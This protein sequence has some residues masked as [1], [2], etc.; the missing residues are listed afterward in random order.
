MNM[1]RI[2]VK[3]VENDRKHSLLMHAAYSPEIIQSH[4]STERK[5]GTSE[6]HSAK[7]GNKRLNER[8]LRGHQI[9]L[10]M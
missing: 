6:V 7:S 3:A 5:T 1:S 4:D 10:F 8:R 2:S 9:N